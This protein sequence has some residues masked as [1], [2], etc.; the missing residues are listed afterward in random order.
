VLQTGVVLRRLLSCA[1][2]AAL[3]LACAVAAPSGAS[4]PGARWI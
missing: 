2:S 3:A 4:A 1:F